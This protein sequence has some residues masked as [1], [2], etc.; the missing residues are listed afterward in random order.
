MMAEGHEGVDTQV[1]QTTSDHE[2]LWPHGTP[3]KVCTA[4]RLRACHQFGEVHEET[5]IVWQ[6]ESPGRRP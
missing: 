1:W 3:D 6:P 4:L 5:T 2:L